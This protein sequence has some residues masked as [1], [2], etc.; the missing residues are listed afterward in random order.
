MN[1]MATKESGIAPIQDLLPVTVSERVLPIDILNRKEMVEQI[2]DLLTALSEAQSSC[3]FA[4]DGK[5]GSGKTFL[6]NMLESQ[7]R[8]YQAG[9]RFMVFHYN[10][11]QYDYYDEP[12]I[13][14]V[15]AMLDNVEEYTKFFSGEVREKLQSGFINTAKQVVKKVACSFVENKIGIEADDLSALLEKIQETA[16]QDIEEQHEYDKYYAFRKVMAEA[17]E[18]LS[19]LAEKQTLVIVV[20]ELDRCFPDYAIKTLERLHHLF[21]GL[22]NTV[23]IM[24]LDKVQLEYTIKKIFGEKTD[25]D[26]Y[27][28]KFIDFE[29]KIDTGTVNEGFLEKYSDYVA[30]FDESISKPWIG[31]CDYIAALFSEMEIRR[32][33]LLI[34]KVHII[35][36]LLFGSQNRKNFSFFCFE[37]L[38][39]VLSERSPTREN[40]PLYYY[41]TRERRSYSTDYKLQIDDDIPDLL[42]NYIR[43]NWTY[44]MG[45]YQSVSEHGPHYS[46]TLDIPLLLIGYSELVY[47]GKSF[48]SRHPEFSKYA[49]YIDDFKA[50]KRV[51]EI[52]I[53][54]MPKNS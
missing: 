27:L 24:A 47:I 17:R 44:R 16:S 29:L 36:K 22:K 37:L 8:D 5:W 34:K 38:M 51:L 20:D 43:E 9:E 3:A 35:H 31:I 13:A 40:A 10:C 7:L 49:E 28:Q 54:P 25:C 14:I 52:I 50:L 21:A 41:E 1:D 15:S 19:R 45:S 2:L 33:E 46:N 48:L 18:E 30:L 32:Q 23:L 6:L 39:A 42:A 4:L 12:L 53:T 11:W 26:A